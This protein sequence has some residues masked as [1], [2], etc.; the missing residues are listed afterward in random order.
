V[1]FNSNSRKCAVFAENLR[2]GLVAK[3]INVR[4]ESIKAS[5]YMVSQVNK[6]A[7]KLTVRNI[8]FSGDEIILVVETWLTLVI[9]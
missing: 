8:R 4:V 6:T 3:N 7:Y 2:A 5:S 1:D 9:P